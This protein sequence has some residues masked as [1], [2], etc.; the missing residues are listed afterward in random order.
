M[1]SLELQLTIIETVRVKI[2]L[3]DTTRRT[4]ML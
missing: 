3:Q 4:F 1:F 2:K